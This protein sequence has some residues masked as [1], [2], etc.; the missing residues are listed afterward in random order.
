MESSKMNNNVYTNGKIY[1]IVDVGYNEQ[2]FG[3]TTVETI[4]NGWR[5]IR[6]QYRQYRKQEVSFL[7]PHFSYLINMELRIRQNRIG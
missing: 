5:D 2:Y 1:K 3:S 7:T 4:Y 6:T